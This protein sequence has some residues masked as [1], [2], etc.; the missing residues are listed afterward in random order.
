MRKHFVL[1]CSGCGAP[2]ADCV[3]LCPYCGKSTGFAELGLAKGIE[4]MKDGGYHIGKGAHVDIG[5]AEATRECPFCGATAETA[6]RFC[7]HCDA[8]I[9]IERMRVARLVISGG[10]MTIGSGG[11][12]EVVGRRTRKLHRAA[13]KGDLEA[14][15]REID[16][17]DDPDF[18]D[19]KGRRPI[20][21]AAEAGQLE[22]AKWLVAVGAEPDAK[23]D[24]G[25]RPI[26]L[27]KASG[28]DAMCSFLR[29]MGAR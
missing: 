3:A 9:V 4:K 18:Q 20:H 23:D 28:H 10:S 29:M 2:A 8:K 14:V 15:R 25:L 22:V 5:A 12:L 11:R 19:A 26:E 27:A 21:Y 17:G 13:A 24:A 1:R 6:A 7:S 16:E